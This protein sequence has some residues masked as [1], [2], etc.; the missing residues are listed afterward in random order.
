[1]VASLPDLP[2]YHLVLQLLDPPEFRSSNATFGEW[3]GQ[4]FESRASELLNASKVQ[5]LNKGGL[6]LW[7]SFALGKC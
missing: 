4:G 7:N 3:K 5:R 6:E 2:W 1:M